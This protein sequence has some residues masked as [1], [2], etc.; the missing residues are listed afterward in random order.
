MQ[1][2]FSTAAGIARVI[3]LL[4]IIFLPILLGIAFF[5]IRS[6]VAG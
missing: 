5:V 4:F 6:K 3:G 2:M 1:M